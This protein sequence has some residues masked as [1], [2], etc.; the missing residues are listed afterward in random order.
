MTRCAFPKCKEKTVDDFRCEDHTGLNCCDNC[1]K[2][3]FIEELYWDCDL[4]DTNM[5]YYKPLLKAFEKSPLEDRT[6]TWVWS[7]LCVSCVEKLSGYSL[8]AEDAPYCMD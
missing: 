6:G 1:G 7:A 5:N 4:E 2:W 8:D 3:E